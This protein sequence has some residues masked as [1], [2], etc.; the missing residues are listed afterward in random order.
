M[1]GA[2]HNAADRALVLTPPVQL[3][4]TP[5]VDVV[6]QLPQRRAGCSQSAL[7]VL[8]AKQLHQPPGVGAEGQPP[9]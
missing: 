4:G 7:H 8:Q 1:D 9:V 2:L 6:V 5:D 3:H